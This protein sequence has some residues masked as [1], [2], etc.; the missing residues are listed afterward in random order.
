MNKVAKASTPSPKKRSA[1][2]SVKLQR[3]DATSSRPYP[4]DG[5]RRDWWERL[6][7]ALGKLLV[8][9]RERLPD[10]V[11]GGGSTADLQRF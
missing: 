7:A 3:I 8:S 9:I 6:K 5:D 11:A 2:V 10:A 1:P 4:P